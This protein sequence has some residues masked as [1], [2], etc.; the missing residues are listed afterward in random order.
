MDTASIIRR[1]WSADDEE[2]LRSNWGTMKVKELAVALNRPAPSIYN[3]AYQLGLANPKRRTEDQQSEPPAPAAPAS[4]QETPTQSCEIEAVPEPKVRPEKRRKIDPT[5]CERD[6]SPDEFQFMKAMD[7]YKRDN[8]RP[9]PT[10]SEVLEVARAIGY[11][12]IADPSQMPGL[13]KTMPP[14]VCTNAAPD[15]M[16]VHNPAANASAPSMPTTMRALTPNND[17]EAIRIFPVRSKVDFGR[18]EATI[19]RVQ[20][21]DQNAI[22]YEVGFWQDRVWNERWVN[23]FM[24][25]PKDDGRITIG[26]AGEEQLK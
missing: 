4:E 24:I 3:K 8:R 11:R 22:C 17:T 25:T 19:L 21:S 18:L 5:T 12:R 10:W 14:L 20:I 2:F 7:Q 26:F 13:S 15:E 23:E 6:Y 1:P 9:F 16:A